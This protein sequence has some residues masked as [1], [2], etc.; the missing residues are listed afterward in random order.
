MMFCQTQEQNNYGHFIRVNIILRCL[1]FRF[2]LLILLDMVHEAKSKQSPG[3]RS[4][5]LGL[6][7]LFIG[8]YL[9]FTTWKIYLETKYFSLYSLFVK[10]AFRLWID[11]CS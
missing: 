4:H 6:F 8:L 2:S 7:N 3:V 1:Y 10:I 9:L 11:F 5:S